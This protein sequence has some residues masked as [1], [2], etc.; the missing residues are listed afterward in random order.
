MTD[1][2][3][4]FSVADSQHPELAYARTR[5]A[6]VRRISIRPGLEPWLVSRLDEVRQVLADPA[7]SVDPAS[8]TAAVRRA[9]GQGRAEERV[10]LLGRN[11]LSVDPPDHSR[12][13]AMLAGALSARRMA[14]VAGTIARSARQILDSVPLG[15]PVDLLAEVT[16]PLAVEVICTLIG[17]P[18]EARVLF[19][20][21]GQA[22]VSAQLE[23]AEDFERVSDQM[24]GYLVPFILDRRAAGGDDLIGT[25]ATARNEDRLDDHELI[26]LVYQL[27]F[28]GHESSAYFMA[29][30][31]LLLLSQPAQLAIL[32][33]NP[34]LL[35]RAIEE[36]LRLEGPV[37]VP[38]WRFAL[39]PLTIGGVA[40]QPGEPV[41]ALLS[42]AGRDETAH[43][44][45]DSFRIDRP[46]TGHLAFGY[47]I[48]HCMG[49]ALARVEAK[50]FLAM[51]LS[52]FPDLR[53]ATELDA[54]QWRVNLMMRGTCS[55]PV[56]F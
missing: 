31:V 32:R 30:A 24:A 50:V 21:W 33:A 36:M 49:A 56:R 34:A 22:M 5:H 25:L 10:A 13:R 28:A 45:G 52:R 46:D 16:L 1:L 38:T 41:L 48:H 40:I 6:G 47:G 27:F 18:A 17:I 14:A 44:D 2:P 3:M 19:R 55:L 37:K 54:L 7:L 15:R 53:L 26:S 20:G 29:N 51:L 8:T 42:A 12:L 39:R 4:P 23:A 9:I 43:P 35:D 11:L